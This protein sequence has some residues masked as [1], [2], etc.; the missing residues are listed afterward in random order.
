MIRVAARDGSGSRPRIPAARAPGGG[1]LGRLVFFLFF[2]FWSLRGV[3]GGGRGPCVCPFKRRS[4]APA[5]QAPGASQKNRM[6][7]ICHQ[8]TERK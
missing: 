7:L 1:A 6:L 2:F 5:S 3:A 4:A 8:T